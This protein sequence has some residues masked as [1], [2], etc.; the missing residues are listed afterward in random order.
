MANEHL[1]A[2][3]GQVEHLR[4]QRRQLQDQAWVLEAQVDAL[5]RARVVGASSSVAPPPS[6]ISEQELELMR[7][8][9][10]VQSELTAT[11]MELG[12]ARGRVL[13][14][15]EEMGRLG[16]V[17]ESREEEFIILC[18]ERDSLQTRVLELE[19]SAGVPGGL[20]TDLLPSLHA[21][22]DR[23]RD[24]LQSSK[25]R[26]RA[27]EAR[28]QELEGRLRAVEDRSRGVEVRLRQ[29]GEIVI[30]SRSSSGKSP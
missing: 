7:E 13:R 4:S 22:G 27:M 10:A 14:A 21:A 8:L 28:S 25:D 20:M 3:G 11:R 2:R 6:M 29:R 5:S 9:D 19:A 23:D 18:R 24:A 17:M 30:C 15:E 1:R 12:Q 16:S 26:L